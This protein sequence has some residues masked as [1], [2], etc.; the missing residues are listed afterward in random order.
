MRQW[1]WKWFVELHGLLLDNQRIRLCVVSVASLLYFDDPIC[2]VLARGAHVAAPF[3]LVF[4]PFHGVRSVQELAYA[5]AGYDRGSEWSR[6][7][8]SFI[9]GLP[10]HGHRISE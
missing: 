4:K 10:R 9:A 1:E 7:G 5:V 8:T 3:M 2:V 6:P